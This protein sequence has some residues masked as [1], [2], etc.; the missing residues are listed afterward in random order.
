MP[1]DR[2]H[3]QP[4]CGKCGVPIIISNDTGHPIDI[5]DETFSKEVLSYPG[6]VLMDSWAP[7]CAPCRVVGPIMEE[8]ASKYAGKVKIV[9]L[10]VDENPLTASKYKIQNIPTMLLF[11]SGS[12]VNRLIGALPK[13]EIER[14]LLSIM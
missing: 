2:L 14:Y 7:W 12:L 11:K 5:T 3:Q 6:T 4:I 13:E 9:K 10:N 8:L 1:E